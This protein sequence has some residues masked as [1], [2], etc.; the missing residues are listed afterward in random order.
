MAKLFLETLAGASSVERAHQNGARASP[1]LTITVWNQSWQ[2]NIG[3]H[4]NKYTSD[5]AALPSNS[6]L[7]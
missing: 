5:S 6:L 2:L 7:A 3:G 1:R 4:W